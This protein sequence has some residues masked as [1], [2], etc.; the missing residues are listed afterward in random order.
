MCSWR[1]GAGGGRGGS[2]LALTPVPVCMGLLRLGRGC[3]SQ[4]P[5]QGSGFGKG[6]ASLGWRGIPA[7]HA[8]SV[9]FLP[10]QPQQNHPWHLFI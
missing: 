8:V 5:S 3:S 10:V 9:N 2:S 4:P 6:H 1:R 7:P